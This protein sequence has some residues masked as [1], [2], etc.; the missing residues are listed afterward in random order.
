MVKINTDSGLCTFP[1]RETGKFLHGLLDT[2]Y[3]ERTQVIAANHEL[4]LTDLKYEEA[5]YTEVMKN[6]A[7]QH[8]GSFVLNRINALKAAIEDTRISELA[9]H[10][11]QIEADRILAQWN[12]PSVC[13]VLLI[14]E[15]LTAIGPVV[16]A[17]VRFFEIPR[18]TTVALEESG[19]S[20]YPKFI[21]RGTL[22]HPVAIDEQVATGY[23][24]LGQIMV[25]KDVA[26]YAQSSSCGGL[27]WMILDRNH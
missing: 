3:S 26:N 16:V 11:E 20:L 7:L 6:S 1:Q 5:K 17:E 22:F 10:K 15:Q 4:L 9:L 14:K 12:L 2:Q 21:Y 18:F 8:L 19:D 25:T 27:M 13:A 24:G 23:V